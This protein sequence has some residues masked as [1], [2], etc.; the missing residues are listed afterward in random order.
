[1]SS[2]IMGGGGVSRYLIS[3]FFVGGVISDFFCGSDI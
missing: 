2:Y 1:M 3:D